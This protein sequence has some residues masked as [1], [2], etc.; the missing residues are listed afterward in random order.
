MQFEDIHLSDTQLY[1]LFR[2]Y[3]KQGDYSEALNL[4]SQNQQLNLKTIV[5]DNLNDLNERVY[6]LENVYYVEVEDYLSN[7]LQSMQTEV[8]NLSNQNIYD[9]SKQ[10]YENNFVYYNNNVYFCIKQPP[11]GTLPTNTTYWVFLG[12]IGIK[13]VGGLSNLTF[14]GQWNSLSFYNK[15]DVI[16]I[17]KTFYWALQ[18]NQGQNP[19]QSNQ[20]W[21]VLF[22][23][24]S[25]QVIG[26]SIDPTSQL[27]S[28]DFWFQ[29]QGN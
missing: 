27:N 13:G 17:N 5:A 12:L 6:G 7:L 14:K 1:A 24:Q 29:I 28:N 15:N 20:Y 11:V 8:N 3:Y 26:S 21:G 22:T 16:F 19:A 18:G 23:V 2:Q 25:Q 4:L 10:Y 9:N